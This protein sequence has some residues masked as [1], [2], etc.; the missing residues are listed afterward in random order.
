MPRIVSNNLGTFVHVQRRESMHQGP[1]EMS[2]NGVNAWNVFRSVGSSTN[3]NWNSNVDD[4]SNNENLPLHASQ[5]GY[6]HGSTDFSSTQRGNLPRGH[7]STSSHQSHFQSSRKGTMSLQTYQEH[8]YSMKS[9]AKPD[10]MLGEPYSQTQ[11]GVGQDNFAGYSTRQ[12]AK[13]YQCSTSNG[14]NMTSSATSSFGQSQI[15]YTDPAFPAYSGYGTGYGSYSSVDS[16]PFTGVDIPDLSTSNNFIFPPQHDGLPTLQSLQGRQHDNLWPVGSTSASKWLPSTAKPATISPK[17]LTLDV[18]S[19][20]M[21]LSGSSHGSAASHSSSSETSS[22]DDASEWSGPESSTVI[23]QSRPIRPNRRLLPNGVPN[24]ARAAAVLA[25]N[26]GSGTKP[27][28][29]QL[30]ELKSNGN[31]FSKRSPS[32]RNIAR[33]SKDSSK[34]RHSGSQKS[35][36]HQKIEPKPPSP[37]PTHVW[38]DQPQSATTAQAIHYR[39]SRDDFLVKSKLA[40]MSYKEIRRKGG[41]NE[42]ES[43]LRGRFRT[44]TKAKS[45][46]VRKPEWNDNDIRLLK[47]AVRKLTHNSD[48]SKSKV[49]WKLVAEYIANNGGSYHFGN[50][51]CRKRW[52]ELQEQA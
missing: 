49:P 9:I 5:G 17:L 43:T 26:N 35:L 23:Q 33:K 38:A 4:L 28:E 6:L 2:N 45:A 30:F 16:Q 25:S 52:D 7:T 10:L 1:V 19:P 32:G 51:T 29:G 39:N 13:A 14:S 31:E 50:A 22:E 12:D 20:P 24:S 47:K 21:S 15:S 44:L 41:F 36:G 48:P 27:Y 37:M 42:A 46:R 40:G 34:S 3:D 8:T 11:W 18:I